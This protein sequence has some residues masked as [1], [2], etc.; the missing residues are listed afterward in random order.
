MD[1]TWTHPSGASGRIAVPRFSP[2]PRRRGDP[3]LTMRFAVVVWKLRTLPGRGDS[4]EV[5]T[6]L[7]PL[8]LRRRTARTPGRWRRRSF[9]EV[10]IT[11]A[12]AL[13]GLLLGQL[14]F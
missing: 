1:A 4:P 6:H 3:P 13:L 9:W 10:P 5:R 8:R 2:R 7:V 12:S 14:I 11:V